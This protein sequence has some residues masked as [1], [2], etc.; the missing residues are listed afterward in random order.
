[1]N[2]SIRKQ[3]LMVFCALT[4]SLTALAQT[5][6][7]PDGNLRVNFALT[8]Q[9]VPTY[10]VDYKGKAVVKQSRLGIELNEEH[11]LMDQFRIN[12]TSTS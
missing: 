2:H 12:R 3:V 6:A 5:V 11:S 10:Q 1:M 4:A 9:G 8:A 7:S